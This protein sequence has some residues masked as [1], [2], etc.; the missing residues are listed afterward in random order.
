MLVVLQLVRISLCLGNI[1][2]LW[3]WTAS[4]AHCIPPSR[5]SRLVTYREVKSPR[6]ESGGEPGFCKSD[7]AIASTLLGFSL[8]TVPFFF[9]YLFKRNKISKYQL[10][11]CLLYHPMMCTY[12]RA[13]GGWKSSMCA[14]FSILIVSHPCFRSIWI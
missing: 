11:L 2:H 4:S 5:E 7:S 6:V 3:P 1:A 10:I 13:H 9:F 12:T 8:T 14:C